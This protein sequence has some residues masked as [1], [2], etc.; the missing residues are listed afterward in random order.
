[1]QPAGIVWFA[2][3]EARLAWQ[4]WR[5][6]SGL[7]TGMILAM[8]GLTAVLHLIALSIVH[9]APDLASHPSKEA[10]I[11]IGGMLALS[12][13]L[14]LSQ[15]METVTRAFYTS[16]PKYSPVRKPGFRWTK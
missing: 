3:H 9:P 2:A 6:L 4:D 14:M 15:A 10:L 7:G 12:W 8:L 16:D 5:L 1:M 11:T 13:S